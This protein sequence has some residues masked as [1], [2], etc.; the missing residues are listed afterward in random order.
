M[1]KWRS[2]VATT[3]FNEHELALIQL[4][5]LA[6]GWSVSRFLRETALEEA[7]RLV[8]IPIGKTSETING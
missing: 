3:R 8:L 4:A 6:S 1:A 2:E 7:Q 5:A